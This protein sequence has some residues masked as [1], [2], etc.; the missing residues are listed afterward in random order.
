M[1]KIKRFLFIIACFFVLS[2]NYALIPS[3]NSANNAD[4]LTVTDIHFNPFFTCQ[5]N[6]TYCPIINSLNKS[7]VSQWPSILKKEGARYF[8]P[9]H[10]ETN[11][12]LLQSAFKKLGDTATQNK[13]TFVILTGDLLAHNY[14][15]LYRRYTGDYSAKGYRSFVNKTFQ[16]IADELE[17]SLPNTPIYPTLGN[18]DSANGDY[19]TDVN[20]Q[21][22]KDFTRI[23]SPLIKDANNKKSFTTDF[24]TA[25][26]YQVTPKG[27]SNLRLLLLNTN[28]FSKNSI[29]PNVDQAANNQLSWLQSQLTLANTNKQQVWLALHIPVGIDIFKTIKN[30]ASPVRVWHD[31][32]THTFLNLVNTYSTTITAMFSGH[33]HTDG[34]QLFKQT[35]GSAILNTITP[36][37]TPLFGNNP[38]FKLFSFNTSSNQL[39]DFTTYDLPLQN[40]APQWGALYTFS[41]I[42]DVPNAANTDA[43]LLT[44]MLGLSKTNAY[45]ASYKKYYGAGQPYSQP[46]QKPNQYP[47]AW[48]I[49]WCAISNFTATDFLNCL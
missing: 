4:F 9:L 8:P 28:L 17:R 32:P 48:T 29:G 24:L 26:Y 16:L 38:G 11:Y 21:F 30:H 31:T 44:R 10:Q 5:S 23:F 15:S 1:L 46:L 40:A 20:G 22:F 12:Y 36:G 42:Y 14:P 6:S 39:L 47:G 45:A 35:N 3:A 2:P 34:F 18:N 41:S 19:Y 37:V 33:Y 49:Y 27:T 25:G 13:A 43:P 7:K